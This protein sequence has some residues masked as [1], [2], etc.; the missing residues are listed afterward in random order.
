MRVNDIDGGSE[1]G[2]CLVY[3]F[4]EAWVLVASVRPSDDNDVECEAGCVSW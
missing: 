3:V 1:F 2:D 4:N